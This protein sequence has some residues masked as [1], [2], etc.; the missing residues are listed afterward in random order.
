MQI[1]HNRNDLPLFPEKNLGN[2]RLAFLIH[3]LI[4]YY[5]NFE[6]VVKSSSERPLANTSLHLR[7]ALHVASTST[8]HNTISDIFNINSLLN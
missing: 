3:P 8:K 4:V 6:A 2:K 7:R 5:S 1:K